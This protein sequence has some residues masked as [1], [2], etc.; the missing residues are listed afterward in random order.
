[1]EANAKLGQAIQ[2]LQAVQ[3]KLSDADIERAAVA[4]AQRMTEIVR[5][6]YN[7]ARSILVLEYP[8][9]PIAVIDMAFNE[10]LIEAAKEADGVE[11]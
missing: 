5:N 7:K 10:G 9:V 3:F 8:T 1:M 11:V 2:K 4:N 6:G